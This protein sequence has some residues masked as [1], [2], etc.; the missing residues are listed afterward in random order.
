MGASGRRAIQ[1][2]CLAL[3]APMGWLGLRMLDGRT[4]AEELA[5]QP[6]LYLYLL[7]PTAVVFAAFGAVLGVHEDRL[8]RANVLLSDDALTDELTRLKNLRYFRARLDEEHAVSQREESALALLMID[9]DHFKRVNDHH[10][11]PE[12][13]RLLRAVGRAIASVARQGET[14]ARIGGE[15]FALLL[16]GASGQDAFAAAERVRGAV[17]AVQLHPSHGG[18]ITITVSVGCAS[19]G[20]LGVVAP[21]ELYGAADEALYKAKR[22]GR[23]RTVRAGHRPP[24]KGPFSPG[25]AAAV[26][27]S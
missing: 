25:S 15:E 9:L 19:T 23:D 17:A 1:G 6:M 11:H 27:A 24:G 12:G 5:G 22:L 3:G 4:L 8:Q 18:P 14:A 21:A 7:V 2:I 16:P 26:P 10:G 20:D 13:D